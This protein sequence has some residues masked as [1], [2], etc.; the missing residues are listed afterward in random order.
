MYT[1]YIERQEWLPRQCPLAS[2]SD[3]GGNSS[4][5][6]EYAE[7]LGAVPQR[8]SGA[9]PLVRGSGGKAPEAESCMLH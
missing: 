5:W 8:V 2:V 4:H 3:L 9:Q 7:G 1:P 6:G